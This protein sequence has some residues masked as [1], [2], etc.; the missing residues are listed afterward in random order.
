MGAASGRE[1]A[2]LAERVFSEARRFGFFQAVRLLERVFEERARDDPRRRRSGVGVDESPA[3][4]AVRFRA[5]T[6][7]MF[8]PRPVAGVSRRPAKEDD[9]P[10]VDRQPEMTVAFMG[11]TGP[12]GVMP[13]HYTELVLRRVRAKDRALRDFLDVFNHR[14]VSLFY[15]CWEKYRFPIGFERQ[16]PLGRED[17]FT[18]CLAALT[19]RG[20]EGLKSRVAVHDDLFRAHGGHF[21]RRVPPAVSLE[22]MLRDYFELPF[23]VVQFHGD[24]IQLDLAERSRFATPGRQRG[25]FMRLGRDLI[26]GSRVIEA[27]TRFRVRV[28]PVSYAE[29]RELMPTGGLLRP[30]CDLVRSYVGREFAFDVQPV[31][32]ARQAPPLTLGGF[33]PD[34]PRL[35]WNTWLRHEPVD[36]EFSGV[37]FSVEGSGRRVV[38]ASPAK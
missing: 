36:R 7:L 22:A 38:E 16:A 10:G 26:V 18:W 27:A 17:H 11:L 14:S 24:W 28:G 35:G 4:E 1:D 23:E 37:S 12:S 8:P 29:F 13:F 31:L 5:A 3:V 25:D 6:T 9:A 33:G 32:R 30:I 15:R 19:G 20:T 21:A 2:A 34:P